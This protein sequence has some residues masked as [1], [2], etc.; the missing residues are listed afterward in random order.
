MNAKLYDSA[1]K[2]Q[3]FSGLMMPLMGFIGNLGYVVVCI[4]GAVLTMKNMIGFEVI[5]AFML[6]IR[7]FTLPL[8]NISPE[9]IP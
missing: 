2:S 4:V 5:V 3:F 1:W 7:L 6:Y 9:Y 8:Q